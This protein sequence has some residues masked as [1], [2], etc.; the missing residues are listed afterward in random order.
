M[1]AAAAWL[2]R[3]AENIAAGDGQVRQLHEGRENLLSQDSLRLA[4]LDLRA[5]PRRRHRPL[6]LDPLAAAARQGS[7]SARSDQGELG[8]VNPTSPFS[9]CVMAIVAL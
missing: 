7:R 6:P 9:L 2:R 3:R 5:V 1:R 4:V 8:P